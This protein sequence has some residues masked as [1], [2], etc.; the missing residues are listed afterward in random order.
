VYNGFLQALV[1][2]YDYAEA[3]DDATARTLFQRGERE[4]Y[5]WMPTG[6]TGAWSLYAAGGRESDLG[7]HRLVRD[8]LE[9]MCARVEK[10]LYCAMAERFTEYMHERTR[11]NWLSVTP[12][13]K[14]KL[15]KVRF[16]MSKVSTV[17]LVVRRNGRVVGT[18][19]PLLLGRGAQQFT[20]TPSQKGRIELEL[21]AKDYISHYTRI[22][23][24]VEVR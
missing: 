15:T 2:L 1:G 14:G 13:R 16:S 19:G 3:A 5:A 6:D 18:F 21:E 23:K 10:E 11:L 20:F 7:Y 24:T 8:F 12:L 9:A 4:A 22:Y 17:N